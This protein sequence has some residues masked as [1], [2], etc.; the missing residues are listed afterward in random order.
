MNFIF[1]YWFWNISHRNFGTLELSSIYLIFFYP[2]S[3]V[4]FACSKLCIDLFFV[5][6][7]CSISTT[8]LV[9]EVGKMK[10]W[11]SVFFCLVICWPV[12]NHVK[13]TFCFLHDRCV[14]VFL[15]CFWFNQK[16]IGKSWELFLK[17]KSICELCACY[18]RIAKEFFF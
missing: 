2:A 18:G 14:D 8:L 6:V 9:L 4:F 10:F 5:L 17:T 12:H 3:T 16:S 15:F 11:Y 7:N 1:Y 13:I